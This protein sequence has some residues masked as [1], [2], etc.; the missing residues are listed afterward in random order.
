VRRSAMTG[1]VIR[2]R[3]RG[4]ADEVRVLVFN[5]CPCVC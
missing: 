5:S 2:P 1:D 4:I 3:C